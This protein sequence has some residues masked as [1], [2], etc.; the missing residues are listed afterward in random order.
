[1]SGIEVDTVVNRPRQEV[2]DYLARGENLPQWMGAFESVQPTSQDAP[3]QGTSYQYKMSR[4]G[5]STF[6][7]ADFVPGQRIAW[8][9]PPVQAGPGEISPRG[10][11]DLADQDGGTHVR[12]TL[13]PELGGAMKAMGLV[14]KRQMKKDA[15]DDLARLKQL[16][17]GQG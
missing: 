7:Y 14:M 1:M 2:F 13:D 10:S 4:G 5:E 11:F 16:M 12:L 6:Q 17:E 9:G 8:S 15:K 3:A